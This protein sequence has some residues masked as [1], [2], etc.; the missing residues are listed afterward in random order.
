M[1]ESCRTMPLVGGSSRGSPVSLTAPYSPQS[2][3]SVLKTSIRPRGIGQTGSVARQ[4]VIHLTRLPV[5]PRVRAQVCPTLPRTRSDLTLRDELDRSRWLCTTN[6]HVPTLNCSP[7]NTHATEKCGREPLKKMLRRQVGG[8]GRRHYN[9]SN[10]KYGLVTA[11]VPPGSNALR[12]QNLQQPV[13]TLASH[14][15]E[16]SS[17]LGG[18]AHGFSR[19]RIVPDDA[20]GW[21]IFSEIS[22][23]PRPCIP[24]LL[25]IYITSP[26]KALE[27]SILDK[28]TEAGW[29]GSCFN[30][31]VHIGYAI[32]ETALVSDWLLHAAEGT[33]PTASWRVGLLRSR[34]ANAVHGA[35]REHCMPVQSFVRSGDGALVARA[36]VTLIATA[37]LGQKEKEKNY[38][39]G[40]AVRIPRFD[41]NSEKKPRIDYIT[42]IA[43]FKIGAT[44]AERLARSPSTK[45]NK[46][47]SSLGT[48]GFAHVGFVPDDAADR[49]IFSGITSFPRPFIPALVHSH[50]NHLHQ[51]SI[52]C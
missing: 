5:P 6:L 46:V 44:E 4:R 29:R 36:S 48:P 39:G 2:P 12:R 19:V 30:V 50:L 23:F 11:A 41:S 17:I 18:V 47:H 38:A 26:S 20:A 35:L 9:S 52:P 43:H 27:T 25:R 40:P 3:S 45:K 7:A 32:L 31:G 28:S 22:R 15:G 16:P 1:W 34:L 10:V 49:Q 21:R 14:L 13:T 8:G 42:A 37:L 33:Y 51:L 24:G